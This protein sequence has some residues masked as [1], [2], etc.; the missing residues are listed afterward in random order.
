MN[1][2]TTSAFGV[3]DPNRGPLDRAANAVTGGTGGV[4]AALDGSHADTHQP[5]GVVVS[6]IFDSNANAER[7]VAELRQMRLATARFH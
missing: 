6:A 1:N 3:D 2:P 5:T 4:S 7:A